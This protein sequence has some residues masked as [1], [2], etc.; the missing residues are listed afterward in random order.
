M[1][2]TLS[3]AFDEYV[4]F[5]EVADRLRLMVAEVSSRGAR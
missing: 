1:H 4:D 3:Q 2:E 5:D